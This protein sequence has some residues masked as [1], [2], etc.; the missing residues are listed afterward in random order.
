MLQDSSSTNDDHQSTDAQINNFFYA[1]T[2]LK[3]EVVGDNVYECE[4]THGN[5]H[6]EMTTAATSSPVV[7]G[8][9]L[10]RIC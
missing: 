7:H 5:L 1:M 10:S 9:F 4:L 8:F 2:G 6:G 3:V